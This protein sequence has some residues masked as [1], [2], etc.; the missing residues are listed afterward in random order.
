[1]TVFAKVRLEIDRATFFSAKILL[2]SPITVYKTC[3]PSHN[4]VELFLIF[5][6]SPGLKETEKQSSTYV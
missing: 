2:D 4:L 1:M 5:D 3:L 6:M